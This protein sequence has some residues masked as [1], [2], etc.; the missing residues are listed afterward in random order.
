VSSEKQKSD[1]LSKPLSGTKFISHRTM[2]GLVVISLMTFLSGNEG[3][4]FQE[5]SPVTWR[6]TS[7]PVADG[8][9]R[10][11]M[12]IKLKSP[13]SLI[14][15]PL[16]R[17]ELVNSA[18]KMCEEMFNKMII[19]EMK[20]FCPAIPHQTQHRI[21]KREPV[22]IIVGVIVLSVM[23]I[24]GLTTS[25]VA[26]S[27]ANDNAAKL[28][29]ITQNLQ[30]AEDKINDFVQ[31][32]NDLVDIVEDVSNKMDEFVRGYPYATYSMSYI[33]TQ[34]ILGKA[35]T[36]EG[37]SHWRDGHVSSKLLEFWNVSLPCGQDCPP[38]LGTPISCSYMN[39]TGYWYLNF[40]V[41]L[42]NRKK[43]ILTV[44]PF[45]LM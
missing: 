24:A 9:E 35:L 28:E 15:H 19:S 5:T 6:E 25:I 1:I 7:N 29:I 20:D 14:T 22:T 30:M 8:Y 41:P 2:L 32:H 42:I 3:L 31:K 38:E 4:N 18:T 13:C 12:K 23:A 39:E 43:T 40:D 26:V 37:A 33:T 45:V 44:D 10:V 36:K 11:Y 21:Q 17:P 34:L 27:K 16:I